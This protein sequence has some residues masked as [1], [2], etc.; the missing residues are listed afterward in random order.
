MFI[1]RWALFTNYVIF[2]LTFRFNNYQCVLW[3]APRTT[4][5]RNEF[6]FPVW[7]IIFTHTLLYSVKFNRKSDTAATP[8]LIHTP[9][10]YKSTRILDAERID[11][12]KP[13]LPTC[14]FIFPPQ[15]WPVDKPRFWNAYRHAFFRTSS[16]LCPSKYDSFLKRNS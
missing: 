12:V 9:A 2:K 8:I 16:S 11:K 7:V 13:S 3:F 10:Y 6:I 4:L 5:L 1:I 15:K 14:E